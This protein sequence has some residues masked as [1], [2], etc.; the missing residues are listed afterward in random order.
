MSPYAWLVMVTKLDHSNTIRGQP[1]PALARAAD[2]PAPSPGAQ[3]VP[4]A[5]GSARQT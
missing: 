1:T 2:A 5:A 3:R 4:R